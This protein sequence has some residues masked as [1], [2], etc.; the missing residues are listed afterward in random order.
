MRVKIV[1]N[2]FM[3]IFYYRNKYSSKLNE[4]HGFGERKHTD[5]S[6]VERSLRFCDLSQEKKIIHDSLTYI[7]GLRR[8]IRKQDPPFSFVDF[9]AAFRTA[10]I[11]S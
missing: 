8:N 3:K 11:V 10:D 4:V 9:T 6:S 7:N 1:F 2:L 5:E